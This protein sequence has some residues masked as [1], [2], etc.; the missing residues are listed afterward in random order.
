M[1]D[2]SNIRQLVY[3]VVQG[4]L[5]INPVTSAIATTI[6]SYKVASQFKEN[7]ERISALELRQMEMTKFIEKVLSNFRALFDSLPDKDI[8]YPQLELAVPIVNTI[9][10]TD[11]SSCWNE[12]YANMLANISSKTNC[13]LVHPSFVSIIKQLSS[14]EIILFRNLTNSPC[15]AWPLIDVYDSRENGDSILLTNFTSCYIDLMSKPKLICS[16]IDN[17]SRLR[18][19]D[20]KDSQL[21]DDSRYELCEREIDSLHMVNSI[22]YHKNTRRIFYHKIFVLTQYGILFKRAAFNQEET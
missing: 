19:I 7:C 16:Y 8:Q 1:G 17:L 10:T 22:H 18:L 4:I 11:L 12:L 21:T 2:S 20:I 9:E 5:N 14:D 13:A 3:S 15:C 6:S